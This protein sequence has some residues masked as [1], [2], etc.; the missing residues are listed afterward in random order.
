MNKQEKEFDRI[1]S[2][3][4][5]ELE[6]QVDELELENFDLREEVERLEN[7]YENNDRDWSRY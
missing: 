2:E 1:R 5:F 4:I 7:K 3:Y 6:K